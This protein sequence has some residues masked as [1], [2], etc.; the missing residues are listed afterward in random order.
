MKTLLRQVSTGLYFQGPDQW[1]ANPAEAHN[2]KL[3]D[4]ALEFIERWQLQDVELAFA[5][6]DWG[7]VTRVPLERID[8]RYSEA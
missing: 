6:K 5:F 4:R 2:F 1:T 7:V 3:I 8:L